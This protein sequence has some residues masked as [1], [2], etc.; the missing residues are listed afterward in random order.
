MPVRCSLI[1]KR[2]AG[3]GLEPQTQ[4]QTVYYRNT[5]HHKKNKNEKCFGL[6]LAQSSF[7]FNNA[8]AI[9][10]KNNRNADS[11]KFLY[12]S[13]GFHVVFLLS[14]PASFELCACLVSNQFDVWLVRRAPVKFVICFSRTI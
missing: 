8:E 10:K 14:V 3:V 13:A 4:K 9:Q 7:Q 5:L 2:S 12:Y 6:W 11:L 1:A